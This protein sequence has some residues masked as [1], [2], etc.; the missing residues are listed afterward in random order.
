LSLTVVGVVI[1]ALL[2]VGAGERLW[3]SAVVKYDG[4]S[5]GGGRQWWMT[6]GGGGG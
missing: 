2:M 3:L 6:G 5:N 1:P 4:V